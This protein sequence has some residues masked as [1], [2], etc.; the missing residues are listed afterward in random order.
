[1]HFYTISKETM[2]KQPHWKVNPR[3]ASI[4]LIRN[5]VFLKNVGQRK[6]VKGNK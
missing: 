6:H 3:I 4:D 2:V 5:V 1:M